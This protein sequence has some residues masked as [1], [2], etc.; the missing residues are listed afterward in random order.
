MAKVCRQRILSSRLKQTRYFLGYNMSFIFGEIVDPE[1]AAT[2]GVASLACP[3]GVITVLSG[4][5]DGGLPVRRRFLREDFY[6]TC[7]DNQVKIDIENARLF[8]DSEEAA[9]LFKL[10][11]L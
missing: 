2:S 3:L 1:D 10:T 6:K 7:K 9:A 11:H 4:W 5:N 8:F